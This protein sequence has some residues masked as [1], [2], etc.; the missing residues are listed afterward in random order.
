MKK[1]QIRSAAEFLGV[2]K[3]TPMEQIKVRGGKLMHEDN[4][5]DNGDVHVHQHVHTP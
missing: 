1:K 2:K 4:D 3:L 5:Y